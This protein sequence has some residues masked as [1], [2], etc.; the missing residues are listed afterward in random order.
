LPAKAGDVETDSIIR[1]ARGAKA[2]QRLRMRIEGYIALYGWLQVTTTV[3]SYSKFFAI[4]E[5]QN[6]EQLM[7]FDDLRIEVAG[8]E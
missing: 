1:A 8:P 2:A 4:D 7:V 6:R 5:L 3:D